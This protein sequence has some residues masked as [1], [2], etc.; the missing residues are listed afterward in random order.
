MNVTN[1]NL[2]AFCI[3]FFH[4]K[5]FYF[6]CQMSSSQDS[7]QTEDFCKGNFLL[8]LYGCYTKSHALSELCRIFFIYSMITTFATTVCI[9]KGGP[10]ITTINMYL[11]EKLNWRTDISWVA[12]ISVSKKGGNFCQHF[13]ENTTKIFRNKKEICLKF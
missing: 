1:N 8:E 3:F 13:C 5:R 10:C 7:A 4:S 6:V 12:I 2:S 11:N 9:R